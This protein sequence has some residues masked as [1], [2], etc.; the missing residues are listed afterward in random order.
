[1]TKA[2]DLKAIFLKSSREM[3]V[4]I[5][6]TLWYMFKTKKV[7]FEIFLSLPSTQT[8]TNVFFNELPLKTLAMNIEHFN[9]EDFNH[10]PIL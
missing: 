4:E 2:T 8:I 1:M 6:V 5:C 3:D 9:Y 10:I 7:F